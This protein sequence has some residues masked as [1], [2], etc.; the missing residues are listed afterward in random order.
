MASQ[1]ESLWTIDTRAGLALS[2]NRMIL[3]GAIPAAVLAF[4]M[5]AGLAVVEWAVTPSGLTKA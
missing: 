3:S 5:D 1:G 2:D 4:L